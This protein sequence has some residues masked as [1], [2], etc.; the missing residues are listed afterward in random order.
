VRR[1]MMVAVAL[2][3][4]GT[5]AA[6]TQAPSPPGNTRLAWDHDGLNVTSWEL[7]ID[8]GAPAVVQ[9]T[10]FPN[11]SNSWSTP[12]PALTPG[13]HTLIMRACNIG[14]CAASDPFAVNV[15][16]VPNPFPAGGNVRIVMGS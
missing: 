8:G 4:A 7:V 11:G 3:I 9:A 2:L 13:P 10:P 6:Q 15:V 16:V 14:G 12:F 1:L 5:A